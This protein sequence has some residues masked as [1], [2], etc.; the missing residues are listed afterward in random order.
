V[1]VSPSGAGYVKVAGVAYAGPLS[2]STSPTVELEAVPAAG[3][4]FIN[5]DGA[6]T[7]NDDNPTTVAMSCSKTVTANFLSEDATGTIGDSVWEDKDAD[8]IRDGQDLGINGV[9]VNL[10]GSDD[11]LIKTTTTAGGGFYSFTDLEPGSYYLKF[12]YSI[13]GGYIF[14]PMDQGSNDQVDSDVN[15][16]GISGIITLIYGQTDMSW[17]AGMYRPSILTYSIALSP[18][19]QIISLPLVP[20]ETRPQ[21]ALSDLDYS[22]V[23]M[24]LKSA[25]SFRLYVKGYATEEG[26]IWK[27]G[28]GYWVE[29]NSPGTLTFSGTELDNES[30]TQL[31]YDVNT[32]WNLIGYKSTIPRIPGNYLA[33]I[34][35]KYDIV[36]GY[37]GGFFIVGP[38]GNDLMEPGQGYWIHMTSPGTIYPPLEQITENITIQQ[39][40]DIINAVPA[41]PRL[42]IL[43]VRTPTE[44]SSGHIAGAAN[45][46]VNSDVNSLTFTEDVNNLDKTKMYVVY[47]KAGTRS[48]KALNIMKNLGFR[49][50]YNMQGG[51]DGWKAAGFPTVP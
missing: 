9:V 4:V 42:V 10:Y 12:S 28:L 44:F 26:F 13:I 49:E 46:D 6:V 29:M 37:G 8:G 45:L 27:D 21:E 23:A 43:D 31:S 47:C 7:G 38:E 24:Y 51:I 30:T 33:R 15:A 19:L 50:A 5:W 14:S 22:I 17:D 11:K 34:Q 16:K 32:G 20:R 3:Y 39:A 1:N 48:A 40:H 25:A 18:G 36:Y 2:Y 41:D 35:G